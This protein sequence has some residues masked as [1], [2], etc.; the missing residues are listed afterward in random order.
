MG[1]HFSQPMCPTD[2]PITACVDAHTQPIFTEA[3][4]TV[5]HQPRLQRWL[6][7]HCESSVQVQG[8]LVIAA[9]VGAA[10]AMPVAEWPAAG[11]MTS[12]LTAAALAAIQR[13]RAVVVAP[14]VLPE[15]GAHNRVLSVP[16]R[17]GD[18]T[19]GAVAL[20]VQA[21][22]AQDVEA[23]FK[24][25]EGASQGLDPSLFDPP[26]AASA[27]APEDRG[28][29]PASRARNFSQHV[30]QP[31]DQRMGHHAAQQ[32]GLH[33][34][35][36]V[37]QLQDLFL[38]Q[39]SL[40]EAA[41]V[42]T[43]ALAP[44]LGCEK[45]ALALL[46]DDRLQLLAV[47]NSAELKP[48]Q[49][50]VR[51][52]TAAM[53]EALDQ[54]ASVVYPATTDSPARLVLA[55]AELHQHSGQAVASVALVQAT[56]NTRQG[57]GAL[58][59]Q[60]RGQARPSAAQLDLLDSLAC[61]LAPLLVLRAR[62]EEGPLQRA[63]QAWRG[64][65]LR[66]AQQHNPLPLLTA[67][68]ASA[69]VAAAC[70]VYVDFR[71]GASARIEGA[72]QRVVAAPMDG[73]LNKSL[74]RPGDTVKAGDVLIEMAS[75]DLLLEQRK[76]E[77]ALAQ[78][79]NG[80]AAAL[81]RADRAQF[82]VA[83]GKASEAAAQLELVRH[84]LGRTKLTAPIDGVVIKGD[85]GQNLGAPVQRGDALMTLAPAEQYRLMVE[86]DERDVAHIHAGQKGQLALAALPADPLGFV[87]ERVTP[88]AVVRDGRNV[89][90]VEARLNQSSPVLRPGLQGVVKI[91]SGQAST[92]W[93]WGHR[94][95]AWLRL[96]LWSWLP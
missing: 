8:G 5:I 76:W 50:A 91:D 14:T 23:I 45:V 6:Q 93:I 49:D 26:A 88:V 10:P 95:W 71:V 79:E 75:Q 33:D 73:F 40:S 66:S 15:D 29:T 41:L 38:R 57:V 7:D 28:A 87:I 89:F 65:R 2:G 9:G 34:A 35:G 84:Q 96:A 83:Q 30:D 51:W 42:L 46:R 92:A 27:L 72:V 68:A 94:A 64:A 11:G 1:W 67:L 85:I 61:V 74:V 56:A 39:A 52:M 69:A 86:V 60:W 54:G 32:A 16:L 63:R 53:Q 78:H 82:V 12:P 48:Q 21:Q 17:Q 59:A 80:F 36:L 77:A 13:A 22:D 24:A 4:M 47:S 62:A 19:L 70:F 44:M 20:A 3:L 55:H 37:L 18:R 25:L 90:E 43:T 31:V 81:A 58:H